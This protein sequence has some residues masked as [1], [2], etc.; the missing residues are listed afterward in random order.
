VG[1]S[2]ATYDY[3]TGRKAFLWENGSMIDLNALIPPGSG[4]QLSLAETI[5]DRGEIAVNGTP[6]GCG[7]VEAFG[8]AVLLIPCDENHQSVEGCDYNMV[9]AVLQPPP[10]P[11]ARED[12]PIEPTVL[13]RRQG[14][15]HLP[16]LGPTN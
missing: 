15:S 9:E 13:L 16:I 5:N 10:R 8:H 3:S 11:A 4:M 14:R 7:L 1:I 2:T 12:T 6:S